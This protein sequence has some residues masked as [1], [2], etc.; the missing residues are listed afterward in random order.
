[1]KKFNLLV[2]IV[3]VFGSAVSAFAAEK[4]PELPLG[5]KE[6]EL[7][8]TV[9]AIVLV[10]QEINLQHW[11]VKIDGREGFHYVFTD[12]KG[13]VG[14]RIVIQIVTRMSAVPQTWIKVRPLNR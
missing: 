1:M 3:L 6:A 13:K 11:R 12:E 4:K 5:F 10:K 9:Q 2:I 8:G 7:I 14:D